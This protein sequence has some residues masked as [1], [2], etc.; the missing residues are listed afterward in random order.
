MSID[1]KL[2]ELRDVMHRNI[3]EYGLAS[4]EALIASQNLDQY[5]NSYCRKNN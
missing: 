1:I 4:K 2:E 5:M 3:S